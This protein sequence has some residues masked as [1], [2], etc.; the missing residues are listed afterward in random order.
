MM[1]LSK[2]PVVSGKNTAKFIIQAQQ[3][4]HGRQL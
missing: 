1:Q 3:L 4:K 2:Q